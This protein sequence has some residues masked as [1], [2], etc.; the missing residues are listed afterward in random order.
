MQRTH[1]DREAIL[2]QGRRAD[3]IVI[4]LSGVVESVYYVDGERDLVLAEWGP[5]HFIGAPHIFGEG[6]QKWSARAVGRVDALHLDQGA[7]RALIHR[8]PDI[9]IALI[10]AI[11]TKGEVCSELAQTLATCNVAQ[12]LAGFLLSLTDG[13]EAA[14]RPRR[15][16]VPALD[17]LRLARRIGATRQAVGRALRD[18]RDHGAIEEAP[19]GRLVDVERLR[20][21][22]EGMQRRETGGDGR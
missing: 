16:C 15:V 4:L 3:G 6:R 22:L 21:L 20:A 19:D 14:S 7:L 13:A 11:G 18:L 9:A 12:R 10:E 8:D 5:G 17:L 2:R 1:G